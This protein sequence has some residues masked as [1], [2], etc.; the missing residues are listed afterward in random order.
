VRFNHAGQRS[1]YLAKEAETAAVETFQEHKAKAAKLWLAELSVRRPLRVLNIGTGTNQSLLL[2]IL[3]MS[4]LLR[5]P[6]SKPGFFQ[7]QYLLT[8][9]LA[10]IVR[11]RRLDGIVYASSQEYPFTFEARGTNLVILR[12]DYRNFVTVERYARR[13]WKHTGDWLV[14]DPER[15]VL[16]PSITGT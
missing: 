4:S 10:D 3:I 15:M 16:E 13:A 9:F 7:P 12:P 1:L 2:E 8:R 5:T 14:L 11:S 6:R